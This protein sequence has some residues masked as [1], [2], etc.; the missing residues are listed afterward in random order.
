MRNL[1]QLYTTEVV[2]IENEHVA[3]EGVHRQGQRCKAGRE[4]GPAGSSRTYLLT[5]GLRPAARPPTGRGG[6]GRGHTHPEGLE[7]AGPRDKEASPAG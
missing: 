5:K 2:F 4:G 3:V 1:F 7:R 6:A